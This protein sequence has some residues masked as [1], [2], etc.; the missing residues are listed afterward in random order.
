MSCRP[1][2]PP[3]RLM[4]LQPPS[5]ETS[6][7]IAGHHEHGRRRQPRV[8]PDKDATRQMAAEI[9][10]QLEVGAPSA[11]GF[12][13]ISI[14][15]VRE[16]WLDNH[17]HIRRSSVNTIQRYRS[18]T[19]H[20]LNFIEQVR[21]LRRA[22][23]FRPNHAEEFVRYLRLLKTAPNGHKNSVKRRLR[24]TT[25]KF[26][27][28][29]CCTLFNYA[30]RHRHLS[31]YAENPFQVIEIGRIPIEDAKPIV[32]FTDEQAAIFLE[33]CDDWQFPIFLTMLLTGLRP[34][35]LTHLLL[36]DDLDL[37]NHWLYVR[38]KQNLGW[39]VKTRNER[40]IPLVP[41]LADVLGW[42]IDDRNTGPVFRQRRCLAGHV[43]PLSGFDQLSLERE[44]TRRNAEFEKRSGD[45]S[46]RKEKQKIA[47]SLWRDVGALRN[48]WIR[49]E[50]MRLTAAIGISDITA[51]KTFR[52][53]FATTL[54]DAN[55]DPLIRNELMGHAPTSVSSVSGLL[56]SLGTTAIYTHTRPETKRSQLDSALVGR[57]VEQF[58]RSWL[59]FR[60]SPPSMGGHNAIESSNEMQCETSLSDANS[61]LNSSEKRGI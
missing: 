31:P 60:P 46:T 57:P 8:G 48:D 5:S 25:V 1:L 3:N 30:K 20:L 43:S 14:P 36:P 16:R 45:E 59:S 38:N 10:A 40:D 41:A 51:P 27:L 33:A 29:T 18:A 19:Q 42:M 26:I 34:G 24:D 39:Q 11:L 44:L 47:H 6:C 12:E 23:D 32:I 53:T 35:E 9:N 17:E 22:S 58:A 61:L 2:W 55:V 54:Q 52:H 56:R 49:I 13:P 37:E 21:P 50:F 28:E 7:D 15:A 4:L